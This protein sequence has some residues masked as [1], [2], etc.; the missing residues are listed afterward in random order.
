V[1]FAGFA[2]P[3]GLIGLL[4]LP[5]ILVLHLL[6]ERSKIHLVSS[7]SLWSFLEPEV[8][9]SHMRRIPFTWLL[10][11]DLLI[12]L[13]LSIA[14]AQ[15]SFN[16]ATIVKGARHLL[17]L[18]DVSTSMQAGDVLP[19]R[20]SQAQLQAISLLSSLGPRDTASV[21]TFGAT[22]RWVGDTRQVELQDLIAEITDLQAGETGHALSPALA[23]A[24]A[25]KDQT[26]PVD[27][28][29]LTD[30]AFP[31][32]RIRELDYPEQWHLFGNRIANQAVL[33]ISTTPMAEN[34]FQVFARLGN[35][36]DQ[37][38]KRVVTLLADGNPVD[39]SPVQMEPNSVVS[40]IWEV[41]GRP[42]AVTVS[43]AGGDQLSEDDSATFGLHYSGKIRIG[44]ITETP[45]PLDKAV[46]SIPGID[47]R[48]LSPEEYLPGMPFD[49]VIFRGTLPESWP[50]GVILVVDPPTGKE[51]LAVK[52][53]EEIRSVP[54]PSRDPL[55]TGVDFSG[56]RWSKAWV[57]EHAPSGFVALLQVDQNPLLMRGRVGPSQIYILLADLKSG[58]LTRHPAFPILIANLVQSS[59]E[60]SLPA[61][62]QT[63]ERLPLPPA[64]EYPRLRV[65][66]P[67]G[68]PVEFT[69]DRPVVWSR[70]LD[71]GA[72]QVELVDL[73]G[74]IHR[75]TIGINA[76]SEVESDVR[77]GDWV[78]DRSAKAEVM[79][80]GTSRAIDLMPWLLGIAIAL[81]ILEAR[82]AWR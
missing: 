52:G 48:I 2:N 56:V 11:V 18:L 22:P 58:N 10:M 79:Q 44:F 76:G 50:V 66:P 60:T 64:I 55:L 24:L 41:A 69:A 73:D 14:W 32:P 9:G 5:V 72:Y 30:A 15:P 7:L 17:I 51:L 21:V 8:R 20:F 31:E 63:G 12:G 34:R 70:T 75:Y 77:P 37:P 80:I 78:S 43:L 39:S 57:L 19:S 38:I 16:L 33:T 71:P 25:A 61:A 46:R 81:L 82:L 26:I 67:Q 49:L 74:G 23:L 65:S 3:I 4:C 28:H 53:L 6:R 13:V 62:M 42:A 59:I 40:Q 1:S 68:D 27:V 29:I 35:F 45:Q 47:L 54:V 36:G